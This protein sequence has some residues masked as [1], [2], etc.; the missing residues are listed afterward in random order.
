[1]TPKKHTCLPPKCSFWAFSE[2]LVIAPLT[3]S[4][5]R[6]RIRIVDRNVQ[7]LLDIHFA[8]KILY[9]YYDINST[10]RP[11]HIYFGNAQPELIRT[12]FFMCDSYLLGKHFCFMTSTPHCFILLLNSG[13]W[14]STSFIPLRSHLVRDLFTTGSVNFFKD[15]YRLIII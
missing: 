7:A 11:P 8:N 1:L 3:G 5:Y 9:A 6:I 13:R 14:F 10:V 4:T 2:A 12:Y 15:T